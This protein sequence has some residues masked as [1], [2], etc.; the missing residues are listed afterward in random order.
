MTEKTG[1]RI[2]RRLARV[3]IAS[4]R[5]AE[6]LIADGRVTVN[7][8]VLTSP[9]LNVG[10]DD[11]ILLDGEAIPDVP[12]LRVWRFHKPEGVVVTAKDEKN[13]KTVFDFLP[14]KLGHVMTVGR[15]DLAS[16]GLLLLTNDG[17]LARWLELPATGWARRYRVRVFGTPT[18]AMLK[19]LAKGMTVEGV[20][21][22]PIEARIDSQQGANAWLTVTLREG[23]NREIRRVMEALGLKVN[24]LLRTA[25][26]PFQLGSLP[27]GALDEVPAK[28]LRE[29]LGGAWKERIG[30][31]RRRPS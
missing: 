31:Y 3:G 2:A 25:Y 23:K 1:E 8:E 24:R 10:P 5:E 12:P 13:R 14:P 19:K 20:S 4:R 27:K 6:R 30:A 18:E 17:D 11:V 21:Y 16:E 22:G 7:G 28:T 29:Q 15:L 26:G 9:A